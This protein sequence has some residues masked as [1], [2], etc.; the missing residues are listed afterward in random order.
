MDVGHVSGQ[1]TGSDQA[2]LVREV[3]DSNPAGGTCRGHLPPAT[4]IINPD[5][6]QRPASPVP[7]DY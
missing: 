3:A 4:G 6:V 5:R 7:R 2:R 1:A